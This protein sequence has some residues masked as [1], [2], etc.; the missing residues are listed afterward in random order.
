MVIFIISYILTQHITR[1]CI[2]RI[3]ST[4][5]LQW[6]ED[7]ESLVEP[8]FYSKDYSTL[9]DQ[10]AKVLKEKR[11]DF[12]ILFDKD[13]NEIIREG[14]TDDI[15]TI[16]LKKRK[17]LDKVELDSGDFYI[18]T[19]PVNNQ[20]INSTLGFIVYGH[21]LKNKNKIIGTI[22]YY[23]LLSSVVVFIL[24]ILFSSLFIK[25]I[26]KPLDTI[27]KGLEMI[28]HG[29]MS[30]RI[31]ID[32]N[33]EYTFLA[34]NYNRMAEQLELIMDEL[35]S[36]QKDLENQVFKRTEA[37]NKANE[38]LKQA[39]DE[40]K[41]TQKSIIQAETQ[42][43]LTSIVSGFAHEINNP[44]TGIL[45]YI[46]LMELNDTLSPYS[47]R[48]LEGI[49][50]LALR[51]KDIIDELNQLDP[52]IEQ[53]KMNINLS[54]LL[55]KLIKIIG[56]ENQ[57][58]GI[59]FKKHFFQEDIIV[60]GNHFALWQVFEGIIENAI[61]AIQ[62]SNIKKGIIEI[63]LKKSKDDA[64][65]ITEIVDNGGGF[66]NIDKAFNPF[67][68][69]KS[70]TRKKGIGLS[71]AFNLISEHKGNILIQNREL[72]DDE[73]RGAKVSVY[74][75]IHLITYI[76]PEINLEYKIQEANIK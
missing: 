37:L 35:E 61:E 41:Y 22:K 12:I 49:K 58:S 67:Y 72:S 6:C 13:K 74:L 27:K 30:Y 31:N 59:L 8:H 20:K 62:D 42:K 1:S 60:Q 71:I 21:S 63:S 39:M 33:D 56:K 17:I 38:K 24:A 43:S 23:T 11:N 18:V 64:F 48:R 73:S 26:N 2:D 36:S 25:K 5:L 9:T 70:R 57:N 10:V 29:I 50:D 32:T 55:E 66:E 69:T 46:D 34:E 40:L 47:K 76:N 52:E 14:A 45:G 3:E 7:F 51:I 16:N 44:L 65:A 53:T 28:S 68:T 15:G 19:L 54:N 4:N 75:P